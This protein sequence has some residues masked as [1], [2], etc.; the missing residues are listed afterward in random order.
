[1]PILHNLPLQPPTREV[2]DQGRRVVR[3][4]RSRATG[5][6]CELTEDMTPEEVMNAAA[7]ISKV[8]RHEDNPAINALAYLVS[9][10]ADYVAVSDV[11]GLRK[12][13]EWA[14][15]RLDGVEK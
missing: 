5:F 15:D 4:L 2:D 1:M 7:F 13:V 12:R 10:L 11:P 14:V 3:T 8:C 6:E 9:Q